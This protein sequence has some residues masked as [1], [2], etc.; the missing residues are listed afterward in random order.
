MTGEQSDKSPANGTLPDGWTVKSLPEELTFIGGKA[1]ERHISE[2]GQYVVV[3]SKFI[4]SDGRVRKF[5][6]KNFQPARAD[7]IL[8]VMSDLPNGKALAKTFLVPE[9]DKYAVNQ[10]VCILRTKR[11]VPAY[12]RYQLNRNDYFLGFDDGV[13]QT[14]LL[15]R[16]FTECPVVVPATVEE[17]KAIAQALSDMDDLIASLDA[18]IAKKRDIKQGAMQ[19]LL[20]GKRRLPG[21]SGEWATVQITDVADLDPTNLGAATPTDWLFN[22]ISLEDVSLGAL[23]GHT[24]MA[25]ADAPSRARRVIGRGDILFGTVR[26]NLKSHCIF[27]LDGTRWVASTGFC[28]IRCRM[29]KSNADYIFEQ[30]MSQQ[31]D[32]QIE[33]IIAGSNYPAVSSRDVG[34]LFIDLPDIEEQKAIAGVMNDMNDEIISLSLQKTKLDTLRHGMM[35]QLLTGRIRL[36]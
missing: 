16:V 20:T 35:Q 19:Q 12:F 1:H 24:E 32:E 21:F 11:G 34:A 3:N 4:S 26:P 10:R 22:Y 5:A 29:G 23:L 27:D 33:R 17:Q 2:L 30:I 7:D 15:N 6:D 18:L 31:V 14:H 25:F 9:A 8:M 13:Q 28:V 36:I